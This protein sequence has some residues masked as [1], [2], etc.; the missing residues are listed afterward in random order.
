MK[1]TERDVPI[2]EW[3]L[4]AALMVALVYTVKVKTEAEAR[5]EYQC[6]LT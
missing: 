2:V 4:I 3:L 5:L 1:N 6:L